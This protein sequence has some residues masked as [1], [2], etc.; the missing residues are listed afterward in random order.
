MT[1]SQQNTKTWSQLQQCD[2]WSQ[3][4][5]ALLFPSPISWKARIRFLLQVCLLVAYF[6]KIPT[7]FRDLDQMFLIQFYNLIKFWSKLFNQAIIAEY[8]SL[9]NGCNSYCLCNFTVT[10]EGKDGYA[11]KVVIF[12]MA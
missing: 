4:I 3:P 10:F 7:I 2:V 6:G 5:T 9:C 11:R 8:F 1:T 12:A